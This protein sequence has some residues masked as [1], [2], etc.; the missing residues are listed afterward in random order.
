VPPH[1][2][3][4]VAQPQPER[5]EGPDAGGTQW[6]PAPRPATPAPFIPN[7][8]RLLPGEPV[9]VSPAQP[10]FPA[11]RSGSEGNGDGRSNEQPKPAQPGFRTTP[12][13]A[14]RLMT[15]PPAV[16]SAGVPATPAAPMA[17]STPSPAQQPTPSWHSNRPELRQEPRSE[18]YTSQRV[19]P[20]RAPS[21]AVAPARPQ[22]ERLQPLPHVQP[23]SP[24]G[25]GGRL[26]QEEL[27]RDP[28]NDR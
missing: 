13:G 6:A 4:L 28:R 5:H 26:R 25:N 12:E 1:P 22:E 11:P 10:K 16:S 17:V 18:P 7:S 21:P 9:P 19:E 3:G 20:A 23:P 27:R 2:P 14:R 15:Q 8:R 24:P